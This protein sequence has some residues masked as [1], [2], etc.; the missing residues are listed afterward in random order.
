M[1]EEIKTTETV[2]SEPPKAEAP[3]P[4]ENPEIVKLRNALS[5][6]NSE[7]A[8]WKRQYTETLDAQK[9]KELEEAEQ[10]KKEL[11]ELEALRKDKRISTYK[12]RLMDT[13]V[14]PASADIMANALPDGVS[15]DYFATLKTYLE[16]QR[17]AADTAALNNQPKLSVGMPPTGA[18]RTEEDMKL[19]KIFGLTH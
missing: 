7:A 1:A 17:K 19:D 4:A 14:D 11:E 3:A 10:R 12:N 18:Q 13:G 9:Q 8:Q 15:D 16:T 6:A 2:A 5:R